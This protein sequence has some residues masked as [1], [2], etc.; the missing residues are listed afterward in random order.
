MEVGGN[1]RIIEQL[2]CNQLL[3]YVLKLIIIL[4]LVPA[5]LRRLTTRP[6]MSCW[7]ILTR[8]KG[9]P[10]SFTSTNGSANGEVGRSGG[11][12]GLGRVLSTFDLTALGVGATLG[13]GV[14]VLAG[15][16]SRDLAGP[17]VVLS[18]L[19]AALASFMAGLCYAEFGGR[20][21]KAGS[22]YYYSYVCIGEIVAFITGWNMILQYVIG[23]ASISRGLSLYLDTIL[24][25]MLK[26]TFREIA[27]MNSTAFSDYFDFLAL[28]L[29][30]L[31]AGK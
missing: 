6:E 10:P 9:L 3:Y 11:G 19:I 26:R 17:S 16:V 30:L 5:C 4:C 21:P 27:P 15:H 20:V 25:D 8:R 1:G 22:A 14:Y 13:V 29:P 7:Q 18:F 28:A 23:S 12:G 24:N 2:N 31:L